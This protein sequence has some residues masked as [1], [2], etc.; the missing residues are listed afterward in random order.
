MSPFMM[1]LSAQDS[2]TFIRLRNSTRDFFGS[3]VGSRNF[4]L[5]F[6][7]CYYTLNVRS[8]TRSR[9]KH[10]DSKENKSNCFLEG[11]D[12]KCFVI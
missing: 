11:P 10:Q 7:F 2:L 1:Q 3:F 12:I 8:P 5:L 4:F 9:G 6:G